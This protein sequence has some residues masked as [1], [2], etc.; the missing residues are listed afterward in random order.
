MVAP[1]GVKRGSPFPTVSENENNPS[2]LPKTLWS[3]SLG[4]S[5]VDSAVLF[6]KKIVTLNSFQGLINLDAEMN[7]A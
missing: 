4:S 1:L 6:I 3:F 5:L 7:S 2:F